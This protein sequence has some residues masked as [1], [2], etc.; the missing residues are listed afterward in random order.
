M[1]GFQS[2]IKEGQLA[3]CTGTVWLPVGNCQVP[4]SPHISLVNQMKKLIAMILEKCGKVRRIYVGSVLP[5]AD[6]EVELENDVK[7]MNRVAPELVCFCFC[8]CICIC[9]LFP[10]NV[11]SALLNATFFTHI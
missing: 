5:R 8:F 2:L 3:V 7:D 4:I 1:A 6:R 9:S 10:P 11:Y